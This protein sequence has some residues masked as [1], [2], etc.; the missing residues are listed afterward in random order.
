MSTQLQ[1]FEQIPSGAS[2]FRGVIDGDE[3]YTRL[4][5]RTDS[6]AVMLSWIDDGQ[7]SPPKKVAKARGV[8][9]AREKLDPSDDQGL[10]D[11]TV[12]QHEKVWCYWVTTPSAQV[13]GVRD[14]VAAAEAGGL[15]HDWTE[16]AAEGNSGTSHTLCTF[17]LTMDGAR[18]LGAEQS[19]LLSGVTGLDSFPDGMHFF[20]RVADIDGFTG[21]EKQSHQPDTTPSAL[22]TPGDLFQ[23]SHPDAAAERGSAWTESD[24]L[25]ATGLTLT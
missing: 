18:S 21:I 1:Y 8:A 11:W 19:A 3:A 10:Y 14:F 4:W 23:T 12:R 13:Q 2:T 15:P 22:Y 25:S 9:L 6:G 16:K 5:G 24:V 17:R 20:Q 7:G